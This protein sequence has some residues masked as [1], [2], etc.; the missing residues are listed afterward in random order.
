MLLALEQAKL[1]LKNNEIPVGAVIVEK[2][3]VIASA[4]NKNITLKDPTAHAEILAIKQACI[5][6]KTLRLENCD[7]YVTLEPCFM[8][9]GAISFAKIKRVYYG[10]S[11]KK[12]GA[13]E[14]EANIFSKK[15]S[16]FK[17]EIYSGISEIESQKILQ[18]FFKN[19]RA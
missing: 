13:I 4:Y 6:K 1:A 10:A 7:I 18:Q 2:N 8:C 5:L 9:M 14:N 3:N 16:Y 15:L 11:E 19:K 12:F 17:P